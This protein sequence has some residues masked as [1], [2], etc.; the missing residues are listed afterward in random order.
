[1]FLLYI[2]SI[3]HKNIR[4]LE[5]NIFNFN[6]FKIFGLKMCNKIIIFNM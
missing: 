3:I 5:N 6:Y 1:M 4:T 2:H